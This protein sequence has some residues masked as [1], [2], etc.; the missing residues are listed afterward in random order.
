MDM[1]IVLLESTVSV[2][3]IKL[4]DHLF[5]NSY[6]DCSAS[7]LIVQDFFAALRDGRVR[8]LVI[9]KLSCL[10]PCSKSLLLINTINTHT[11][12]GV[13]IMS[14]PSAPQRVLV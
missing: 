8:S 3:L 6:C 7:I 10:A 4:C 11:T 9:N 5:L 14:N 2:A 12:E 1:S 13:D